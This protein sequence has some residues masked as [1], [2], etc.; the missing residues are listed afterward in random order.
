[1]LALVIVGF[2]CHFLCILCLFL[3]FSLQVAPQMKRYTC[4]TVVICCTLY[5]YINSYILSLLLAIG[6]LVGTVFLGF[7]PPFLVIIGH[8]CAGSYSDEKIHNYT[9]GAICF[10]GHPCVTNFMFSLS[11]HFN[12]LMVTI[13]GHFSHLFS[14]NLG[15]FY[16]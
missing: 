2:L 11:W 15:L 8:F 12:C 16:R 13:F 6:D 10:T 14:N 5:P 1:M 3:I 9:P 4:T 7:L